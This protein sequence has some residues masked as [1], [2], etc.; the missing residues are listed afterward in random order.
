MVD[1]R[2]VVEVGVLKEWPAIAVAL[3]STVA[4]QKDREGLTYNT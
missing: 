2:D 4:E 3:I 1:T